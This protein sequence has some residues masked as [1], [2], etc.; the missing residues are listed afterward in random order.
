MT[1][2]KNPG[3]TNTAGANTHL[4]NICSGKDQCFGHLGSD[5][6]ASDDNLVWI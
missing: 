2:E 3:R 6:I 1:D 5:N 4:D